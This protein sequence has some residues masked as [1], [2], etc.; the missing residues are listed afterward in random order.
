MS[1]FVVGRLFGWADFAEDGDDVW[2]V[3]LDDQFVQAYQRIL[4]LGPA[5]ERAASR[6]IA[7]LKMTALTVSAP[8]SSHQVN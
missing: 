5:S 6:E 8:Y 3:H 1:E 4:S 7:R 2:I